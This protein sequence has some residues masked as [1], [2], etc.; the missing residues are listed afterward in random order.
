MALQSN[1]LVLFGLGVLND[2]P[3]NAL[4]PP[5]V[6]G[7]HLRWA[8]RH[9][10]GFPWYGFFLF[11][12]LSRPNGEHA[13]SQALDP[14]Q[15]G[16]PPGPTG[17]AELRLDG[18]YIESD[19]ELLLT[20]DFPPT[21][22]VE[23]DLASG[24][25]LQCT[26]ADGPIFKADVVLGFRA[27]G[28]VT[29]I[30]LNGA[31]P[32]AEVQVLGSP[33]GTSTVKLQ[34]DSITAI[35]LLQ[36][37]AALIDIRFHTVADQVDAGWELLPGL[38]APLRL[39]ITHPDYPCTP[40]STASYAT[41]VT[42]MQARVRYGTPDAT[43]AP[44]YLAGLIA[45]S[46]GSSIVLGTDTQ[47]TS[48]LAG[49]TLRVPGDA[50]AYTVATVLS[51]TVLVLNQPYRGSSSAGV[52]N[53]S[54]LQDAY[55]ELYDHMLGLT[56]GG[57]AAGAMANRAL[58]QPIAA[59]G[60]VHLTH[61]STL[62]QGSST[63]WSS[64]MVGLTLYVAQEG[65]GAV[66]VID[67]SPYVLGS[68][69]RW[70]QQLVG[71]SIEVN[72]ALFKVARVDLPTRLTL[73]RTYQGGSASN[74]T[75]RI[76]DSA[77]YTIAQVL[78]PT[79]LEI[80]RPYAGQSAAFQAY[81]LTAGYQSTADDAD[82][83]ASMR[84]HYPLDSLLMSAINPAIAQMLGLYWIDETAN[85]GV[86]YDYMLV[87][88][89]TGVAGL[90]PATALG[91]VQEQRFDDIEVSVIFERYTDVIAPL[92]APDGVEVY[93][94]PTSPVSIN[95]TCATGLRWDS[96]R[97]VGGALLPDRP[98]LYH[99]W[100]A[101]HAKQPSAEP[102]ESA[103][104]VLTEAAPLLISDA[105]LPLGATPERPTD[106]PPFALFAFDRGL[107][108][109]WYSYQVS[110]IDIFGRHSLRS[111]PAAWYQWDVAG[112]PP[113][114][115]P[116]YYEEP[117]GQRAIHPFAVQVLDTVAPPPPSGVEASALDP[118]DP[119]LLRDAAYS[120]WFDTLSAA[121]QEHVIGLRVRWLW[122]HAHMQ[123]AP[124]THEFRIYYHSSGV[125]TDPA[126]YDPH[127]WQ[128]RIYVVDYADAAD[129]TVDADG[130]PLRIYE[131]LLPAVGDVDRAGLGLQ[132][133]LAEPI[134]YAA[135]GVSA[136]D[137]KT[138]ASDKRTT[139]SWGNR[140]GN[141]GMI[142]APVTIF[143]VLR[144]PPPAPE[145]PP[146]D[147]EQLLAT[148]ADYFG[149]SFFTYRWTP[150]THLKAHIY[151]ALD[152]TLFKIDWAQRPRPALSASDASRFPSPTAEPRWTSTK[153]EQVAAELNALNTFAHDAA[154]A[155]AALA[156]YRALSNDGL[157]ILAGL[158]GNERAFTQLTV[159]P[160]DPA[161]AAN[162]DRQ[163]P[164]SPDDYTPN[165]ALRAFQDTLDGRAINRYCY[166]AVY[167]NGAHN[168]S[169]MS[170][171]SAPV[172]LPNVVP[173]RAPVLTSVAGGDR[174]ISLAWASNREPD[175]AEY[176]VYR[177]DS[178]EQAADIRLMTLV[179]T[180]P[181]AAD[182]AARPASVT[183][184]DATVVPYQPCFYRVVAVDTAGNVSAP[185]AIGN[186]AAYDY[187]IPEEP[188]WERANWV[189]LDA[190]NIEHP[191][192]DTAPELKPAVALVV[193]VSQPNICA[194]AQRYSSRWRNVTAWTKA[195]EFDERTAAWRLTVY[196][197]TARSDSTQ[198]YRMRLINQAGVV[199]ESTIEQT[200]AAP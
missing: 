103:Y 190:N 150:R 73:D 163:G 168:R 119:L 185:S 75:Y 122:T 156:Y 86:A 194:M 125:L 54:L 175:L 5:L 155:A 102:A 189:K 78:S 46:Q 159:Q 169:S 186:S 14:A 66:T 97:T 35:K 180:A 85:P 34:A 30:A 15:G 40:G 23:L 7:M 49:A 109:G 138:H 45:V 74:L 93:A 50:D 25:Y 127:N 42:E 177:A 55:G 22:T 32:V 117:P 165:P 139:G 33:G 126:R 158:P 31:V 60:T 89:Y 198:R 121:E 64:A 191:W 100:R 67:G 51:P 161:D 9:D 36:G 173:P 116:W 112:N 111:A 136:A 17:G 6:D 183:W 114:P 69:T 153:R 72:G 137:D 38:S 135:V 157:R 162:A 172:A 149:R 81:L 130:N 184:A 120:A 79:E 167:V 12:R 94:L 142:G 13:L 123:Q 115:R 3:P 192:S 20:Q 47:W 26:F 152:E 48:D 61:E 151:R 76:Y 174:Q 178:A 90:E 131:V 57:P 171:A 124:D 1:N 29:V 128:E 193:R 140:P 18:F 87:A 200:V 19:A 107:K 21:S 199:L 145:P 37:P 101:N 91:L 63:S 71:M 182:P 92:A 88:D 187:G 39:P 141:E 96:G 164:D 118:A 176:R 24:T 154:G 2:T 28:T 43:A 108:D 58:P 65:P 99:L 133:S 77:G 110:G 8:F 105:R 11:R 16:P 95:H 82:T 70:S 188:V 196:D 181:A 166:R 195:V 59:A 4:Q 62:V 170:L 113:E 27:K 106:W 10:R 197:D 53:Y 104:A 146:A 83:G 160:L 147:G 98:V 56:V 41:A 144:E 52:K 143:R 134:V 129:L 132:P 44:V 68:G 148:P 84:R 80:A 179:H